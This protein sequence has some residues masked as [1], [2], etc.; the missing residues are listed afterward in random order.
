V[1]LLA[2]WPAFTRRKRAGLKC[3]VRNF[4]IPHFAHCNL[5]SAFRLCGVLSRYHVNLYRSG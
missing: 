5:H 1:K 4:R 2:L 3:F